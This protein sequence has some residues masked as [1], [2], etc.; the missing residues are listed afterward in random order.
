MQ[1]EQVLL[2][3]INKG[4]ISSAIL[5]AIILILYQIITRVLDNIKSKDKNKPI[6]EMGAAIKEV[7]TNL[8]NLNVVLTK[9]IQDS[10]KRDAERCK[11]TIE[12]SFTAFE[13]NLFDASRTII[14]YNN[15]LAN[16][17]SI[18]DNI[19]QTVNSEYYK[20]ISVLSLYEVDNK[21]VAVHLKKEWIVELINDLLNVIYNG[22]EAMIRINLIRSKLKAKVSNYSTYVYNKTFND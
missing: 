2:E 11:N 22:Q 19:S 5:L 7:G 14:V 20:I 17:E 15:I 18:S 21:L 8:T 9:F 13:H 12:L 3:I 6:V 16:K 4:S 10:T 1:G